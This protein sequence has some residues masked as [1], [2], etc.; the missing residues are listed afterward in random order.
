LGGWGECARLGTGDVYGEGGC[1]GEGEG[2][3]DGDCV[4]MVRV[5]VFGDGDG[6]WGGG[7]EFDGD[8]VR[9]KA[10]VVCW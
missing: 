5:I 4:V 10:M 8:G 6:A 9:V 7:G 3:C 2:L 1:A